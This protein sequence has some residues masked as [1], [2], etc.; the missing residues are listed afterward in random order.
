MGTTNAAA[1]LRQEEA[2][3]SK[4]SPNTVVD[5]R[6]TKFELREKQLEAVHFLEKR[7][8]RAGLF[9]Q[10][11]TGKTRT[12]LAYLHDRANRILVVC[13]SSTFGSWQE[14]IA[15]FPCY[16]D[17]TVIAL[18]DSQ[19]VAQ[20]GDRLRRI[21]ALQ[22]RLI[23]LVNIEA[24]W[25]EALR[26]ALVN[27]KPDAVVIDE[28]HR[29]KHHTSKQSKFS[30]ILAERPYVKY[31]IALTG[32]PITKGLEDVYSLFRFIDP[33][34][35]GTRWVEFRDRYLRMGGF[36][37]KQIIGYKN[38]EELQQ[39]VASASFRVTRDECFDIPPVQHILHPV[40]LDNG[41]SKS[42]LEMKKKG[43]IQLD[44]K[45]ENGNPLT[46][47]ALAN[48]ALTTVMRLQQIT[49]GFCVL[50]DTQ[51]L[52]I[53]TEKLESCCDLV[54]ESVDGGDQVVIFCRF[55]RD[56]KRLFEILS[57]SYKVGLLEGSIKADD[58]TTIIRAFRQKQLDVIVAQ[59]QVASMGIDLATA[60]T[61]IF[62]ST[63]FSFDTFQQARD[64]LQG[65]TQQKSVGYYYLLAKLSTGAQ[66]VD[67]VVY[68]ALDKRQSL[69]QTILQD[70]IAVKSILG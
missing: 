7:N 17:Y 67:N 35:F 19:T 65:P 48:I 33:K 5:S 66:T 24:Y 32:T 28:A 1:I 8:G 30:H 10:Q 54:T 4:L 41:T 45:D 62:Y 61:C 70:P 39:K 18:T 38:E 68:T 36:S 55:S 64:R 26:L 34:I 53:S 2:Q 20:R 58:R 47:V 44:G 3:D 11:R 27:W 25:R 51:T 22:D 37:G 15:L 6:Y 31:C 21:G 29:L 42:Y 16:S 13:T 14:E 69:A 52:D 50:E 23:V 60:G 63:P 12:A 59:I 9:M 40:F 43:L 49:S 46:G 56:V 57:K